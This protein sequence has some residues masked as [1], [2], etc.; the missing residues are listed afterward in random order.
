MCIPPSLGAGHKQSVF[1]CW[2]TQNKIL[3]AW[4]LEQQK[5]LI[6]QS[7]RL[8]SKMPAGLVSPVALSLAHRCQPSCYPFPW[9]SHYAWAP[10]HLSVYP[11]LI[12]KGPQSEGI[13][14][15]LTAS[16]YHSLKA[17]YLHVQSHSEVPG[18]QGSH[19]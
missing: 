8:G 11:H 19:V 1:V 3:Q 6:S 9:S 5:F 17:L 7:W 18:G 12:L 16:L 14:A 4:M 15:I 2:G 10:Q 13:K